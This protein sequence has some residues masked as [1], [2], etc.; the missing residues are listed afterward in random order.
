MREHHRH[1]LLY[2]FVL[3]M[4]AEYDFSQSRPNPYIKDLPKQEVTLLLEEDTLHYFHALSQQIG[5]PCEQLMI[6][7]LQDCARLKQAVPRQ[8]KRGKAHVHAS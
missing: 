7:Y 2:L 3:C 6:L 8:R 1:I 4:K 5:V